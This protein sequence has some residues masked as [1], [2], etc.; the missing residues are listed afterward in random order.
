MIISLAT[1]FPDL[2]KPFL[3]TSLIRRAQ[4]TGRVSFDI[5]NMLSFCE[6]KERIDGPVFGHGA[7]MVIRPEVV[8][9][10]VEAQE[11]RHGE[12]FKIF[13]SP[14]GKKLDQELLHELAD[15]LKTEKHV[16]L[17]A[18]R[19]EGMDSRVEEHYA[20]VTISMG[21][22]VV[23]G[24]DLPAMLL[25]EAFLRL[26][27]GVVGK[28]ESVKEDSF[29][30]PFVDY[31]HYTAPVVWKGLEVPEVVRSGNHKLMNEWRERYVVQKTVLEH[32]DWLRAHKVTDSQKKLV[33]EAMPS[34]YVALMHD[35]VLLPNGVVGTTSVTS[36]DIHDI[37]RSAKTYG[38]K[39]YFIVTPLLDQQRIARKLLDFWQEGVGVTYNPHRHEA[40]RETRIINSL[41]ETIKAIAEREGQEP[42]VIATSAQA[43]QGEKSITYFDQAKVWQQKRPVLLLFGTGHGLAPAV[44]ERVDFVL[45]PIQGYTA[46]NHLSVRSAAA[47]I[48]DRWLGEN[49][50]KNKL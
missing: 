15:R 5:A 21:D 31:P 28:Q 26:V 23:M 16:M 27:P 17:L 9:R 11:E 10:V 50:Q 18:A 25:L 7:G 30:G 32:F 29:S 41:H 40:L 4:E 44:M 22:F 36:L 20:D 48:F 33:H 39:G 13:F 35:E 8:E 19:Y 24:G 37:A 2:Y 6:P 46:F 12:A 47:V 34:H 38:L 3:S 14:Q 45:L 42:L 1:L 43:A 49:L